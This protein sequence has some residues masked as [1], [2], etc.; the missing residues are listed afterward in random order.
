M[1]NCK[2]KFRCIFCNQS[3]DWYIMPIEEKVDS[4]DY[5]HSLTKYQITCKDCG[6]NYLL[7]FRILPL[8]HKKRKL[9]K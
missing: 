5:K 2:I 1:L 7:E 8:E 4:G 3:K 6:M 9:T